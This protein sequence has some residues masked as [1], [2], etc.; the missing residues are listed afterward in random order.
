MVIMRLTR[1][2]RRKYIGVTRMLRLTGCLFIIIATTAT[3]MT[4]RAEPVAN[5][6]SNAPL[7]PEHFMTVEDI[8]KLKSFGEEILSPN[9]ETIAFE[10]HDPL[11]SIHQT[12][13]STALR[14]DTHV[15]LAS[16]NTGR[17]TEV[18]VPDSVAMTL[19]KSMDAHAGS[20]W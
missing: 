11:A 14:Y 3:P 6:A 5:S 7:T 2:A 4:A 18:R 16:A 9:G 15:Y 12:I 13:F 17:M 20:S 8:L 1:R 19:Y 10:N